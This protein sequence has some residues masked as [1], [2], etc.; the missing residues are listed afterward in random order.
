VSEVVNIVVAKSVVAAARVQLRYLVRQ[1]KRSDFKCPRDLERR[2]IIAC[3][4]T[5]SLGLANFLVFDVAFDI[6]NRLTLFAADF[7]RLYERVLPTSVLEDENNPIRM[8]VLPVLPVPAA[9]LS[10]NESLLQPEYPPT[11][12]FDFE[13]NAPY[14]DNVGDNDDDIVI[15]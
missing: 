2:F 7:R 1:K 13:T 8:P 11:L 14:D 15:R 12:I 9:L 3:C 5:W 10:R 6:I 4:P